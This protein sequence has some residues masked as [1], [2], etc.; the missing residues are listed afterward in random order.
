MAHL[1]R[2]LRDERARLV[3]LTGMGG[4]GKTRLAIEAA[5]RVVGAFAGRAWFVDLSGVPVPHLIPTALAQALKLPPDPG[6]DPLQR[7]IQASGE[8]PCL[9]VLDNF[10]HLLAPS[11]KGLPVLPLGSFRFCA[12]GSGLTRN[13]VSGNSLPEST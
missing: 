5:G 3:T 11:G 12:L 6:A 4:S 2:L 7:V 9:L 1:E 13:C 8:A 10:E